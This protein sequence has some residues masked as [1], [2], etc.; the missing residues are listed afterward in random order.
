MAQRR[1]DNRTKEVIKTAWRSILERYRTDPVSGQERWT[2]SEADTGLLKDIDAL[3]A[4]VEPFLLASSTFV[5][6]P[7][8]TEQ[9]CDHMEKI[10]KE[11]ERLAGDSRRPEAE[12]TEKAEPIALYRGFTAAP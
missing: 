1:L 9:I 12:K 3:N 6:P 11:R 2:D 5:D 10:L 8:K 4:L 7:L